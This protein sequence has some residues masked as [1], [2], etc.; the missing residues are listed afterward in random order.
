MKIKNVWN[1]HLDDASP[2][3]IYLTSPVQKNPRSHVKKIKNRSYI[4]LQ[5]AYVFSVWCWQYHKLTSH[6]CSIHRILVQELANHLANKCHKAVANMKRSGWKGIQELSDLPL[7]KWQVT[8]ERSVQL[9]CTIV[10]WTGMFLHQ[11][12]TKLIRSTHHPW[13]MYRK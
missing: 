13:N 1:H 12:P 3:T 10:S 11:N 2:F 4:K 8:V 7:S 6:S 9:N 5:R